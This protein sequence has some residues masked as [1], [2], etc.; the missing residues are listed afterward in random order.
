MKKNFNDALQHT[1]FDG[2]SISQT[3]DERE[4]KREP[5]A[6]AVPSDAPDKSILPDKEKKQHR[7]SLYMDEGEL[8]NNLNAYCRVYGISKNKFIIQ[9]IEESLTDERMEKVR[10]SLAALD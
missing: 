3:E 10:K 1:A 9:L 6:V 5:S 4:V 8:L 2:F 7:I